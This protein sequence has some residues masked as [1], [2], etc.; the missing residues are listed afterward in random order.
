MIIDEIRACMEAYSMDIDCRHMQL[1]GDVMTFRQVIVAVQRRNHHQKNQNMAHF[2][3]HDYMYIVAIHVEAHSRSSLSQCLHAQT[4]MHNNTIHVS[5]HRGDVLGIS[6]FG[7]MKMRASTLMLASFEE[8]NEHL[9]EAAAHHRMDD[10][11]G[12]SECIIMGKSVSLGTGAF[13][14]LYDYKNQWT[15]KG[16]E[17]EPVSSVKTKSSLLLGQHPMVNNI[18]TQQRSTLL[19]S[20]YGKV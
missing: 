8:T 15:G 4:C 11:K 19:L 6:R 12:V 3:E 16:L 10:V 14:L 18:G 9:F 20:K 7:I 17:G 2:N 1:L 13:D 5:L